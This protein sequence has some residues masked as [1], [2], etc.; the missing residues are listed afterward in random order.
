MTN[1]PECNSENTYVDDGPYLD[2]T[3]GIYL[4]RCC[5]DC[6]AEWREEYAITLCDSEVIVHGDKHKEIQR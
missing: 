4:T 1:C 3:D 6:S 2:G 5:D